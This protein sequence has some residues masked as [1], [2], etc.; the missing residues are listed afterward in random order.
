M[1]KKAERE[2]PPA[3]PPIVEQDPRFVMTDAVRLRTTAL[4][5]VMRASGVVVGWNFKSA[6]ELT[7]E[8]EELEKWLK[9]AK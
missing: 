4:E 6:T 3:P 9:S 5:L 2:K 1:T 8:A 7:K